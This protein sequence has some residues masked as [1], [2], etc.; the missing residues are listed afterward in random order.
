MEE[1]LNLTNN[2]KIEQVYTDKAGFQ[3]LTNTIKDVQKYYP[4]INKKDIID[5]YKN[6]VDVEVRQQS[7]YNSF[8]ANTP[9]TE[10]Q[11]D[12]FNF[13]SKIE[14][15]EYTSGIACVDVFSKIGAVLAIPNKQQDTL[16]EA[17]KQIF[18]IMEIGRAHV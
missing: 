5:W 13:K 18:K 2:Q 11:I 6:N 12:L 3:N 10:F 9:L 15:D 17:I 1:N 14:G 7:G 8:V 4:E 16:L